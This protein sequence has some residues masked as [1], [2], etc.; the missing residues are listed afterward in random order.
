MLSLLSGPAQEWGAAEWA[1]ES[2]ACESFEEFSE[3]LA[4]T[5]DPAKLKKEAV[6]QLTRISQGNRSVV[7]YAVEFRTLA[8]SC[9]WKESA[10]YDVLRWFDWQRVSYPRHL[11]V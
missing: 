8:V 9:D 11:T 6:L 10:Q 3:E 7:E 4:F 2:P 1:G 5:F